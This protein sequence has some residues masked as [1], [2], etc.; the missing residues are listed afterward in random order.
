MWNVF[1]VFFVTLTIFPAMMAGVEPID[2]SF[3]IDD[4]TKQ[5]KLFFIFQSPRDLLFMTKTV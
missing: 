2:Q 4:E 5:R 1:F 3:W